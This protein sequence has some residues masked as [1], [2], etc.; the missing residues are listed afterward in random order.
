M[1]G[2]AVC[3]SHGGSAPRAKEKALAR[4]EVQKIVEMT[5]GTA[6]RLEGH[7]AV[8]PGEVLLEL[9]SAWKV[10]LIQV[11][12]AIQDMVDRSGGDLEKALTADSWAED[13]NGRRVKTGEHLK[14]LVELEQR[15]SNQL[16]QWVA[17]AIK[18][19]LE[20]RKVRVRERNA[21]YFAEMLR[22]MMADT[23]L[24]L[25]AEQRAEFPRALERV[26]EEQELVAWSA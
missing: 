16:A 3:A 13:E 15:I 22:L 24:K 2:Q 9:I 12:D 11:S 10:R 20:E 7:P 25:T 1:E 5:R 14:G 17:I 26:I 19:G 4:L 18:A 6:W 23:L 21:N 8:D